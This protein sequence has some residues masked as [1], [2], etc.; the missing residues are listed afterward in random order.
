MGRFKIFVMVWEQKDNMI[1][2]NQV[3]FVD[4]G[5][6]KDKLD[7]I[8]DLLNRKVK[9]GDKH[10]VACS[11]DV[12]YMDEEQPPDHNGI[13]EMHHIGWFDGDWHEEVMFLI[14]DMDDKLI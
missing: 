10:N 7:T 9:K 1:M 8:I 14:R 12:S 13:R 3:E 5:S 6:N 4:I 2:A 11:L